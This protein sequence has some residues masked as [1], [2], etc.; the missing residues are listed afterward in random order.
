VSK[1]VAPSN[2]EELQGWLQEMV[3][4]LAFTRLIAAVVAL[5]A[6]LRDLN[7]ELTKQLAHLRRARPR[8]ERLRA[9]EGQL[10]LPWAMI[11]GAA[12]QRRSASVR[13]VRPWRW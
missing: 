3:K 7:T 2:V 9:L 6:R 11:S 5:V 8:S 4:Q 10:L 13:C 1:A 12:Q